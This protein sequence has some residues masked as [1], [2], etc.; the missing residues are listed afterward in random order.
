MTAASIPSGTCTDLSL[1]MIGQS[2]S[3]SSDFIVTQ[4][5]G[6]T[7]S[8]YN[9][10]GGS[11]ATASTWNAFTTMAGS[12]AFLINFASSSS[13]SNPGSGTCRIYNYAGSFRK[14]WT[15]QDTYNHSTFMNTEVTSG[16]WLSTSA[17]TSILL[18][19]NSGSNIV[20]GSKF[21]VRC[22]Q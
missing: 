4:F 21:Q 7:G 20:T 3:G 18:K 19:L 1:S 17:I 13:T 9:I 6:D 10:S 16:E 12:S 15:C 14:Q 11:M 22:A 2:S 5:N 8:N